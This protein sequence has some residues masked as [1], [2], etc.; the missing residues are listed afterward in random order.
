[1]WLLFE[2]YLSTDIDNIR[3]IKFPRF[4][5]HKVIEASQDCGVFLLLSFG[6]LGVSL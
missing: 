1:M 6:I 2:F 3:G 4:C 5:L